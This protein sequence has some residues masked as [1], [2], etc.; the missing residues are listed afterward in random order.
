MNINMLAIVLK[1]GNDK[2]LGALVLQKCKDFTVY[3]P[4]NNPAEADYEAQLTFMH[5]NWQ[6]TQ[7]PL[8]CILEEG[9]LPGPDFVGQILRTAKKHPEFQEYHVN[10]E[11]QKAFPKKA[12]SKK[13]FRLA[14]TDNLD[15]P[16]SS[17]VFQ[18]SALR[19]KA[20][21]KADGS[22]DPFPTILSC[23]PARNVSGLELPWTAAD[24]GNDP[25]AGEKS[26]HNQLEMLRWTEGYFGDDDYPLSVGDQLKLICQ[27]L[28]KL[29]PSYT[30]DE[31][32]E[33]LYEFE[34]T[35]KPIRKLH[36]SC[37]LKK[38]IKAR[39]KAL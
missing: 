29:Y 21:T 39:E 35:R 38:A 6:N 23:A 25:A 27:E 22:L 31:L 7:E 19:D 18:S 3:L 26:V 11:G 28:A 1:N 8:T 16:L 5:G 37:A 4:D 20:V 10:L 34:V 17:F 15:A 32:K 9:A 13:I 14:L 12:D 33:K 2:L 36:A 24:K 30:A